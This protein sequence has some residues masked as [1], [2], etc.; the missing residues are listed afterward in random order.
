MENLGQMFVRLFLVI[1]PLFFSCYNCMYPFSEPVF[2][3]SGSGSG[4]ASLIFSITM[5][6]T[7]KGLKASKL[8]SNRA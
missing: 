7:Y 8:I 6:S 4:S 1:S 2:D 3:G 5:N